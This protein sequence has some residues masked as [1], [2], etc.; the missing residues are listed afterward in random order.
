MHPRNR[1][2]PSMLGMWMTQ[3]KLWSGLALAIALAVVAAAVWSSA[4]T[5]PVNAQTELAKPT[6]VNVSVTEGSLDVTVTWDA[7]AGADSNRVRVRESGSGTE[8]G[9]PVTVQQTSGTARPEVEITVDDFGSWIVRVEA[10]AED[11]R[12]GRGK[13]VA[14]S[15]RRAPAHTAAP[16]PGEP[17]GLAV[18]TQAGSLVVSVDWDDVTGADHYLVRWREDAENGTLNAGTEAETSEADITVANYGEWVVQVQACNS[19]DACGLAASA[20]FDVQPAEAGPSG[21]SSHLVVDAPDN[22]LF[23]Y[24]SFINPFAL[25]AASGGTEPYAYELSGLPDGLEFDPD[26]RVLSGTPRE[27]HSNAPATDYTATYTVTD[28][29]GG[30]ASDTFTIMV[31]PRVS[32]EWDW[33]SGGGPTGQLRNNGGDCVREGQSTRAF[34]YWLDRQPDANV[35]VELVNLFQETGP[36]FDPIVANP[37]SL[38][39]TSS[40]W[41]T[42][43][44]LRFTVPQ[45]DDAEHPDTGFETRVRSADHRF[46]FNVRDFDI[47]G[48]DDESVGI[49]FPKT[50]LAIDEGESDTYNIMMGSRPVGVI[51]IRAA[52]TAESNAAVSVSPTVVEFNRA[53][54]RSPQTVTVTLLDDDNATD[55]SATI[56]HNVEWGSDIEYLILDLPDV[57][58][59]ET[60]DTAATMV[61]L[62]AEPLSLFVKSDDQFMVWTNGVQFSQV[63][64]A[65]RGGTGAITYSLVNVPE[66]VR[67]AQR[68]WPPGISFDAAT[69]TISGT[70]TLTTWMW[71]YLIY[72]A[73]DSTGATAEVLLHYLVEPNIQ[74]PAIPDMEFTVN[75][76]IGVVQLPEATGCDGC[77]Y[78]VPTSN[79]PKGL[80]RSGRTLVGTPTEVTDG[81]VTVVYEARDSLGWVGSTQ[82]RVT[83]NPPVRIRGGRVPSFTAGTAIDP[84][85]QLPVATGG[86]GPFTY[87]LSRDGHSLPAGVT[88]N[89]ATGALSGTPTQPT[90]RYW[91]WYQATDKFGSTAGATVWLGVVGASSSGYGATGATQPPATDT[92]PT[93]SDTSQFRNHEATAG[94]AFSLTLPPA[95]EG[96]GNGGPYDYRL[97]HRGQNRNFMDQAIN[98]LRFDPAT[99]TLSGTPDE[100]GV[101]LLSY[102]V[103][104]N[105]DD[106]SVDDR[107]RE[108][109]NLQVT[110]LAQ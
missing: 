94:E 67:P 53:N 51:R 86:T 60:D 23:A 52:I 27:L 26:T 87:S 32:L 17:T 54:W 106:R 101:W 28:N 61:A 48:I 36:Q 19:D 83:V 49:Q 5:L 75:R 77:T 16:A 91:M 76:D 107:F 43:Q 88:L 81:P 29:G 84:P 13:A 38:T 95:D 64:P 33:A 20:R 58:I 56:S 105:D 62:P 92:A 34:M 93:V 82:F 70:P 57:E 96:S 44:N 65:A 46:N 108:R 73:T 41:D 66:H 18:S 69:R 40:N 37:S 80:Y 74:F 68:V 7:V 11:G 21:Q 1:S 2:Y 110:V 42:P 99:R 104:D 109:T 12:C 50:S 47:C 39:F 79:R 45:D 10:C 63:L 6:N 89:P 24:N 9:D 55:G 4:T 98:G 25:P 78:R 59:T 22:Q 97:W 35:T 14:F 3:R 102:V 15:V 31:E 30:S 90:E 71:T 8:F 100:S 85:H 72:K 103:H